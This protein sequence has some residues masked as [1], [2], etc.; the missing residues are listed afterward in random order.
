MTSNQWPLGPAYAVAA[1]S[2]QGQTLEAAIVDLLIG[3]G[4]GTLACY[5]AFTRV[6]TREDLLIYRAF[7]RESF[8]QEHS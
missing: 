8:T 3:R 4:V 2:S 5:V 7:M 1:H 6:R